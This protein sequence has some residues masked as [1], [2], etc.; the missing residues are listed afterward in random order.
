MSKFKIAGVELVTDHPG[1]LRTPVDRRPLLFRPIAMRG[2]T[3]RNRIMLGPMSQY[4]AQNGN[5]T[6]W[7]LVHL[8]QFGIGGAG[9][10][11]SE[12]TAVEAR[13]RRTHHCAGMYT[14]EHVRGYRRV[15][16]FLKDMGAVPM[17]QLGHAGRRASVRSPWEG[18][19]PLGPRD[20]AEGLGPWTTVSSSA[21]PHTPE[22]PAP[23][24][25][26]RQEIK[27]EHRAW[28]EAAKR[29][30]DAGFDFV[31]I[32][33]AHG[34]LINQFLSPVAN[35]RDD[36][37]GGDLGGRMRFPLELVEAVRASW[38]KDKPLAFRCSV[39]D[40]KGGHWD[41]DDTVTL[42]K[43]LKERGVDFIDCSCG[44]LEGESSL[45]AVPRHIPGYN[46]VYSDHVRREAN[47]PTIVVGWITEPEQA[48]AILREGKADII[49]LAREMLCNPYWP[50]YAARTLGLKDWL[51]VL[52]ENY[53]FR[54][55]PREE[56]RE[57]QKQPF[58]GEIP[59]RRK[60]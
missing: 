55:Y 6:D 4:L 56:E 8:G 28:G 50:A 54:L 41:M 36:A 14:D 44:G 52:P 46:V 31:E 25:L 16:D 11:C 40:G 48:E 26:D 20:A 35:R 58:K 2:V 24:A 57:R 45:P 9:I 17:I 30:A 1:G 49:A 21:I 29:S 7:H 51:D 22:R 34:Y 12:E 39:V 60:G 10:V 3:A 37:Y 43:A 27:D 53:A 19:R 47:I 23:V 13:G 32:H 15:T 5:L 18:R 33:G 59:F 42:A 38:P